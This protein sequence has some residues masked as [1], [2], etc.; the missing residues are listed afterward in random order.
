MKQRVLELLIRARAN[1][2]SAVLV[3]ALETG[4]QALLVT[5]NDA[6]TGDLAL[7]SDGSFTFVP[8]KDFTGLVVFRY[9]ASDGTTTSGVTT[10]VIRIEPV[11]D[12]PVALNDTFTVDPLLRV[13]RPPAFSASRR[14]CS[15]TME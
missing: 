9:Q 7:D 3:T 5:G 12:G 6:A 10:V 13:V 11:N 2:R 15:P 4:A 14:V 1:R 8:V